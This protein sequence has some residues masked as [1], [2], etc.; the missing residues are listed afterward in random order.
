MGEQ[1]I[2]VI[3]A[4]AVGAVL[5]EAA[6]AA[7]HQVTMC[8]RTPFEK[9]VVDGPD[10]STELPVEIVT[11]AERVPEV[12]RV[13]LTTKVQDVATAEPWLHA[14]D[15][16]RTPVVVVQNGVEHEESVSALGWSGPVL[17][18]LIYVGAERVAP[19]H[20][21]RRTRARVVVPAGEPGSALPELPADVRVES[22]GDFRTEAWRKMLMNVAANPIT[23]LTMR[24]L[25]VLDEPG[26]RELCA[27]VLAEAVEVAR[28]EG[29]ELTS[30]DAD[31]VVD[32]YRTGFSPDNG[33]SML[34][35]RLAGLPTEHEHISGPV[36]RAGRRHGIATPMNQALL[37]LMRAVRPGGTG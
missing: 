14:F 28:A 24:R 13:L 34:Y 7:G 30:A 18:A 9:L 27:A 6:H 37:T 26:V 20:V 3:G 29:A 25:D 23:A 2:A 35:D 36:V 15:D 17:P 10:G 5:A 31:K 22:T 33:T 4:G 1:R 19:G 11:S 12:D 21:V 32:A 8:V 16:G